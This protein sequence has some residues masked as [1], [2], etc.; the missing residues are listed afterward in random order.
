MAAKFVQAHLAKLLIHYRENRKLSKT[1]A[2]WFLGTSRDILDAYEGGT[3]Q[4]IERVSTSVTSVVSQ[5]VRRG[6]RVS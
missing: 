3:R 5:G 4:Y 6:G 2:V 1:E